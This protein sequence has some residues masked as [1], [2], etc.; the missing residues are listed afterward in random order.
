MPRDTVK[1]G[2]ASPRAPLLKKS[3]PGA[4]AP[5]RAA[6]KPMAV[7]KPA[8]P[9]APQPTAQDQSVDPG[10]EEEIPP[11]VIPSGNASWT[12]MR[13]L[14]IMA[15]MAVLVVFVYQKLQIY[16]KDVAKREEAYMRKQKEEEMRRRREAEKELAER[17]NRPLIPPP[18]DIPNPGS[19]AQKPTP[20]PAP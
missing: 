18:V 15:A 2:T 19:Q 8:K 3:A 6:G 13:N 4:L 20:E 9:P 11:L 1:N 16:K 17:N 14:L 7:G 5:A 10:N 12:Y